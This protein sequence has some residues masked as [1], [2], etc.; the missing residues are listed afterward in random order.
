MAERLL[1][2]LDRHEALV[3][4]L[5]ERHGVPLH[6]FFLEELERNVHAFRD[7]LGTAVPDSDIAFAVK[8][9]PCRGALRAAHRL[10]LSADVASEY[11]LRVA[12]EEGIPPERIVC[13]GNAKSEAFHDLAI[14]CG[15]ILSIDGEE[16]LR[17]IADASV[18]AG[19][20]TPILLRISGLP[21]EGFTASSQTTADHWSKFG[22]ASA[23][24]PSLLHAIPRLQGIRFLG[25]SAHIG[26]QLCEPAPYL[27]L[28]DTLVR[29]LGE[30]A[31]TGLRT[32]IVDL[33]GGWPVSFLGE[34]EW[35]QFTRTLKQ[36]V[37]G[38]V[39]VEKWVT[40]KG[41]P[42]GFASASKTAA[43][44][45]DRWR[46]KAY[47]TAYSGPQMLQHVLHAPLSSG[48]SVV[49]ELH[50]HASPQVIIEPGRALVATAGVTLCRAMSSKSV[51]G[52]TVIAV[53]LGI[54]NH[55][56]NLLAPD[57]FPVVALPRRPTDTP[58][59]AFLGGRLCFG[60]DVL[61]TAKV[62][63]NR[64]PQHGE[65]VA[66]LATGAYGADHFASHSCGFPRP[67]KVAV[68]EDGSWELWRAA[69]RFSDVFPPLDD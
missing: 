6:L 29:L 30:A 34:A 12:L 1:G 11:E 23:E 52:H 19:R 3:D 41:H 2:Y 47:F 7:A 56:T 4:A 17:R 44:D 43:T 63:L 31:S 18:A 46:G 61:T 40:W 58:I 62:R 13:N 50:D 51:L 16:E 42:M 59:D 65:R 38:Q 57:I 48:R 69:D 10:G 20:E 67:A 9:N 24:I 22:I 55:G 54:N 49:E 36:Q 53:D 28:L 64:H 14:D 27:I 66:L 25:F 60:S 32:R 8:S 37:A 26:T 45:V 21:V 5:V 68:R 33:G 15:A 35:T 39:P